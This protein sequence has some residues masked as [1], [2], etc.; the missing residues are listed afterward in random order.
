MTTCVGTGTHI[1]ASSD[2]AGRDAAFFQVALMIFLG[3]I[4]NGF[5]DNLGDNRAVIAARFFQVLFGSP[6]FGFL[7]RRM[8]ENCGAVL[9]AP[10]GSLP[11]ERGWIVVAP[12]NIQQLIVRDLGWVEDHLHRSEEHTSELQSLRHLVCRLLLEKKKIKKKYIKLI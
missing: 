12:E 10:I 6:C 8:E 7:L 3:A 5:G 2:M 4:E 1:C 11:V 9:R